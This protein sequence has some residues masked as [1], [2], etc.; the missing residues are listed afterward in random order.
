MNVMRC[1]FCA[2][3]ALLFSVTCS[4]AQLPPHACTQSQ[5][6]QFACAAPALASPEAI[7]ANEHGLDSI[8][9]MFAALRTCWMPP[10]KDEVAMGWNTRS[11]S[12]LSAMAR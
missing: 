2:M 7:T 3:I 10:S 1:Y 5:S 6:E 12:P 8:R 9:D 4:E 11:A